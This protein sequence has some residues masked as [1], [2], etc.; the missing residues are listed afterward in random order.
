M[1]ASLLAMATTTTFMGT[2]PEAFKDWTAPSSLIFE[3]LQALASGT[4][5]HRGL[6]RRYRVWTPTF[7]RQEFAA[8]LVMSQDLIV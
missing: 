5:S 4:D 2:Q 6:R 1:R 3:E 7:T 8:Y